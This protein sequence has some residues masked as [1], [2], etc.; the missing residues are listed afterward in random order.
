MALFVSRLQAGI[1][2]NPANPA[3]TGIACGAPTCI[4]SAAAD[5]K[6]RILEDASPG[7]MASVL[8]IDTGEPLSHIAAPGQGEKL[9]TCYVL[10]I[11]HLIQHCILFC[12]K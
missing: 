8:E 5:S 2:G 12:K 3:Y 10:C 7:G 9:M 11:V 1:H 4:V 6:L